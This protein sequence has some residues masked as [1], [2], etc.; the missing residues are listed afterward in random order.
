PHQDEPDI[1]DDTSSKEVVS[2][3]DDNAD[4][5]L[6]FMHAK[7]HYKY[8]YSSRQE[9]QI[10]QL[11]GQ[12]QQDDISNITEVAKQKIHSDIQRLYKHRETRL[13][14]IAEEDK[15]R[16]VIGHM[17]SS[18]HMKLAIEMCMPKKRKCVDVIRSSYS[19][20]SKTMNILSIE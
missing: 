13:N 17:N 20:L 12:R 19:G 10:I 1:I 6:C 9:D 7:H 16:K 2:C 5:P 4:A 14:K 11:V 18:T 3:C 15:Q 8:T